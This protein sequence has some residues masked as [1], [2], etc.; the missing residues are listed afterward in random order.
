M[1]ADRILLGLGEVSGRIVSQ[2]VSEIE[3]VVHETEHDALKADRLEK[4]SHLGRY[5]VIELLDE[6]ASSE[7]TA[8][9]MLP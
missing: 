3:A 5:A 9:V 2:K 1:N 8:P 4:S 6:L 7:Y